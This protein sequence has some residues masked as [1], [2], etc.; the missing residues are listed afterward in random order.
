M[1]DGGGYRDWKGN[2]SEEDEEGSASGN[3]ADWEDY[4][5]E[6]SAS[7][8]DPDDWEDSEEECSV[9]E[10]NTINKHR[11]VG[12]AS[13]RAAT[14]RGQTV[15]TL[16]GKAGEGCGT[17]AYGVEPGLAGRTAVAGAV[18]AVTENVDTAWLSKG[19]YQGDA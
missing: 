5:E 8:E 9:S 12:M 4:D 7:E 18:P 11:S 6:D 17:V 14:Q 13:G 15:D 1:A 10:N 19:E 3:P 16:V 2:C